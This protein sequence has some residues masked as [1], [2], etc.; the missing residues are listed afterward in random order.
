MLHKCYK[1]VCAPCAHCFSILSL[2]LCLPNLSWSLALH[3][4]RP[5]SAIEMRPCKHWSALPHLIISGVMAMGVLSARFHLILD[6][7]N[8][9]WFHER[10]NGYIFPWGPR[11]RLGT[12][13]EPLTNLNPPYVPPIPACAF[14]LHAR[15]CVLLIDIIWGGCHINP[16]ENAY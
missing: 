10:M 4:A 15:F 11:R 12:M 8:T 13:L 5:P 16:A 14:L 2:L 1:N 9:L 3:L 6:G 7:E